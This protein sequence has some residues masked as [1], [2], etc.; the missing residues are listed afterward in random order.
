M[1]ST[2]KVAH[3]DDE[4]VAHEKAKSQEAYRRRA[5]WAAM[6]MYREGFGFAPVRRAGREDDRDE[7][8]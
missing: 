6:T 4:I 1:Q 2:M 3:A 5:P 8:G 7:M